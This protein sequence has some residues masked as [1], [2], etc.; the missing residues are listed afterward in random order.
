MNQ[1]EFKTELQR[2]GY[3]VVYGGAAGGKLTPDHSHEFDARVM[4]I[5]GDITITRGGVSQTF[6]AGDACSIPAGE[7]HAE[8]IGPQGVAFIAGRRAVTAA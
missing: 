4:V 3:Q 8:Q 2:E 7:L 1:S 5:G 6:H